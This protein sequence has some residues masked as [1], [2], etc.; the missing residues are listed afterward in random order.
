MSK[1]MK[2]KSFYSNKKILIT[3]HTGFV[4]SWLTLLFTKFNCK[5]FGISKKNSLN[6]E[7]YKIL[8]ISKNIHKEFFID[9][10][11]Y[12]K[13]KN[14]IKEIKPDIVFHLAA[15]AYVLEG[16]KDPIDTFS[17]NVM[18]TL[19]IIK[20]SIENKIKHNIIITTD[21]CY[22]NNEKKIGLKESSILGGDDPYSASKACAELVCK[23]M[24][25]SYFNKKIYFDTIRAGNILGG[26]DFG[27]DR[28]INDIYLS[29]KN[30]RKLIIRYPDAI[31]P[32]QNILD[33]IIAYSMIPINQMN[34]LEN[35]E[36]WNLGPGKNVKKLTV[37]EIVKK[38]FKIFE[39][40]KNFLIK[41][42]KIKEKKILILNSNKI[43]KKIK[44]NNK[45]NIEET[46]NQTCEWY[47]IY[48]TKNKK[49]LQ[50]Y[51]STLIDKVLE[52]I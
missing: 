20:S 23:A 18:G 46:L 3:G 34:R 29:I 50:K 2:L 40:K 25:Q 38:F 35:Y 37:I 17:T 41:R 7:N 31:R 33:V 28:L 12:Y 15:Q 19:N 16:Y 42:I 43:R 6:D 51:S 9:I 44:W 14:K 32:W 30:N 45:F 39:L 11:N 47:K 27:K 4:G 24:S 21:K 48:I 5:V 52:D 26:G 8:D 49:E 13:L 10:N 1:I 22:V 36:T